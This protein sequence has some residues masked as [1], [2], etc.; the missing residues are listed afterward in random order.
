ML[1]ENCSHHFLTGCQNCLTS[2][3]TVRRKPDVYEELLYKI[4]RPLTSEMLDMIDDWMGPEH[5]SLNQDQELMLRLFLL[6]I[7]YPDTL[8]LE[9]L[10]DVITNDVRRISAYLHFTQPYLHDL[11]SRHAIR[12]K[13]LGLTFLTPRMPTPSSMAPT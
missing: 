12:L 6:A 1:I 2:I 11:G 10:D 3:T 9:S 7:R 13:K 4:H 5:R 8:L